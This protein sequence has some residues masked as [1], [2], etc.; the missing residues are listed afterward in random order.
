MQAPS[1]FLV[2]AVGVASALLPF[3]GTG[4]HPMW[5]LVWFAPVPILAVAPRLGKRAAFLLATVAWLLGD[6]NQWNYLSC[7]IELPLPF[8][9]IVIALFQ[10]FT[11]H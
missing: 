6:L 1:A 10:R 5:W 7:G 3:F 8:P 2:I 4:L 9:L 11:N